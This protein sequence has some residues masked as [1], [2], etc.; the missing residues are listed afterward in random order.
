MDA[1][2]F[3]APRMALALAVFA[4]AGY[5]AFGWLDEEDSK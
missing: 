4:L 3:Y 2:L 1:F 5:I